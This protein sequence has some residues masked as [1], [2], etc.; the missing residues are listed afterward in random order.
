V[1]N[2]VG[3]GDQPGDGIAV[4]NVALP[5]GRLRPP[6]LGRIERSPRHTDDLR[7]VGMIF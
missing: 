2:H 1:H 4:E 7:H 6:L 3:I 5:V